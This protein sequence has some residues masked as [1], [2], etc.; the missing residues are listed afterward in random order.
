MVV[1]HN[2]DFG[3]FLVD[4]SSGI[5]F[6]GEDFMFSQPDDGLLLPT[7]ETLRDDYEHRV[8]DGQYILGVMNYIVSRLGGQVVYTPN[9]DNEDIPEDA[10]L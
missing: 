3:T 4:G 10:V 5:D 8:A 6:D 7:L 1:Y 9:P 2:E